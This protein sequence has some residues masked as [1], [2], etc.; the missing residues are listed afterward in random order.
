MC[1]IRRRFS[2]AKRRLCSGMKAGV[3]AVDTEAAAA[4]CDLVESVVVNRNRYG[5]VEVEIHGLLSALL[6]EG[7]YPDAIRST[8]GGL[9]VPRGGA[10]TFAEIN[11]LASSGTP[12]SSHSFLVFSF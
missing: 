10:T 6:G 9:V 11:A 3:A 7:T 5:G 4:I 8:V 2:R 1:A 12:K